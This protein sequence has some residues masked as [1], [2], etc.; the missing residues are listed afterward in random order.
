M[1]ERVRA[2]LLGGTLE[3]AMGAIQSGMPLGTVTE[4]TLTIVRSAVGFR[5]RT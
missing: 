4:R 5:A 3:A 1:S 2:G